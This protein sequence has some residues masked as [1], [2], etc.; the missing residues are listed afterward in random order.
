MEISTSYDFGTPL[1]SPSEI[2]VKVEVSI[3]LEDMWQL[4]NMREVIANGIQPIL[5]QL[6]M[7]EQTIAEW[8]ER[9]KLS[10][11][12]A[13]TVK[14]PFRYLESEHMIVDVRN[15]KHYPV[16]DWLEGKLPG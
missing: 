6:N 2:E 4:P 12:L 9:I 7:P 1:K 3:T 14:T 13:T 11:N 5:K 15:K 10:G 16:S 8:I